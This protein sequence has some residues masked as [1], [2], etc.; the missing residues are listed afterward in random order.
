MYG[1]EGPNPYGSPFGR[2]H[3]VMVIGIAIFILPFM[4]HWSIFKWVPGWFS[5]LGVILILLGAGLSI[6]NLS[7][8]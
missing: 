7:Q 2:A 4:N 8:Y 5:G 3:P 6:Y 1:E